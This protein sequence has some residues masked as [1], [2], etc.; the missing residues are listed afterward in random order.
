MIFVYGLIYIATLA[1]EIMRVILGLLLIVQ[2]EILRYAGIK[3]QP[4]HHISKRIVRGKW[5]WLWFVICSFMT[6]IFTRLTNVP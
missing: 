3:F 2:P 4:L 5:F 6:G 1:I